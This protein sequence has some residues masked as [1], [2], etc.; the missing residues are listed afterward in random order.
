MRNLTYENITDVVVASISKTEDARLKEILTALIRSA[1]GFVKEV[2]LTQDEWER[3]AGYLMRAAEISDN[4][5]NEFILI[6][7]LLGV[8]SLVDLI[9]SRKRTDGSVSTLLGPFYVEGTPYVDTDGDLVKD[10]EGARIVVAGR[11]TSTTHEPIPGAVL[12]V[13][14]NA[15][16]GLYANVDPSQPDDNLRGR[17]RT[18]A[19]GAYA[20]STI[21]PI[22]YEIP[23]DGACGEYQRATGRHGW[24]PAHVHARVSAEGFEP[25]IT[26]IFDVDDDYID[27]DAV[28]GVRGALAVPYDREPSAAELDRFSGVERPFH[29]IDFDIRLTPA[30]RDG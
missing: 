30:G 14:Q 17:L 18:D 3:A 26:Q 9:G 21:R 13:W 2:E 22:A 15:A 16:S 27:E 8:S 1:H 12:E 5:R 11:V 23:P 19:N 20:F 7:D 24:R 10:N 28:F 6:S 29:M 25:H 4:Q